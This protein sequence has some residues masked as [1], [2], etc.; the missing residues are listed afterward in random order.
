[1]TLNQLNVSNYTCRLLLNRLL[2]YPLTSFTDFWCLSNLISISGKAA[3]LHGA[4]VE[5]ALVIELIAGQTRVQLVQDR[6]Q[7][8]AQGQQLRSHAVEAHAH[9]AL[10][11][12]T[13]PIPQQRTT[14]Q[15]EKSQL[16]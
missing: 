8:S 9:G 4:G 5:V 7:T 13:P 12:Q 1:M 16:L 14:A 6:R 2:D 11:R 10:K 3:A 15:R